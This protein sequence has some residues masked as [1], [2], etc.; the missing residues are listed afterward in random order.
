M[1]Q[2][3][4]NPIVELADVHLSFGPT[5][6][7]KGI[8][9]QVARGETVSII[10]PSGS[11]KSTILR[12]INALVTPQ[13]GRITVNGA[14]VDQM[15]SETDRIKLRQ[16]IG[17]VFQQYNLFPHLTVIDNITLAPIRILGV[18]RAEAE[19]HGKDLL[20]RVRLSEKAQMYPGQLSGGQQQR[21]AI[22][23]ALAMRPDLVLFDEVTSA[24][25]PETVGEVLA[26]IRDLVKEGMT[27]ILVTHEM[28]FAEEISDV[29]VFTENGLIVDKGPPEHIFQKSANPR[30]RRFVNGLAGAR[31]ALED[32]EG[33]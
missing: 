14:R 25:D 33:I 28:R 27:S 12:C 5:E 31:G 1:S 26:V 13:S 18:D 10:G 19:R 2:A 29:V 9:L 11:G 3:A 30:I 6:V 32:G 21:V 20:A 17:I 4:T 7:L 24:L 8:D 23:R 16:K 15:T 22:A